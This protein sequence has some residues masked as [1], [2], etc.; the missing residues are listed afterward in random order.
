M[1][2]TKNTSRTGKQCPFCDT[3]LS[4]MVIYTHV[5]KCIAEFELQNGIVVQPPATSNPTATTIATIASTTKA[6]VK[7]E[8][9]HSGKPWKQRRIPKRQC[10]EQHTQ[11]TGKQCPFCDADLSYMLV[12]THVKKCL[13]EFES[14]CQC[15]PNHCSHCHY[16]NH[17]LPNQS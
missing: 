14:H 9:E 4:Y 2:N 15:C 13:A 11:P 10:L 6:E 12:Y 7:E 8:N 16:Y 1:Y 17:C 3:E 5:K